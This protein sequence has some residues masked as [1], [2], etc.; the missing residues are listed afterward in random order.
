MNLHA[1][2]RGAIS[3]VNPDVTGTITR[4]NGTY[5][6]QADG[7]Q[8]P[9]YDAPVAVT[10]QV[11]PLSNRDL[12]QLDSMNIQGI[13]QAVYVNGPVTGVDRV[14]KK[15][16]DLLTFLGSTWLATAILEAWDP[17]AGWTKVGVVKQRP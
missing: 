11:Q 7:T 14:A 15:G 10:L 8:V 17:T 2:V 4:N 5:T 13:D 16:G 1:I 9:G 6:T 3:S 12:K